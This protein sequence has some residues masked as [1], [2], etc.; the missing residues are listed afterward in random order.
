MDLNQKLVSIERTEAV[1]LRDLLGRDQ[2]LVALVR[3]LG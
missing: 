1:V 2:T 3:H